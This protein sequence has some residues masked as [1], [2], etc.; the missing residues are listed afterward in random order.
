MTQ[1]VMHAYDDGEGRHRPIYSVCVAGGRA[2]VRAMADEW[3][4]TAER[5]ER[6]L[7]AGPPASRQAEEAQVDPYLNPN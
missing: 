1:L 3:A 6:L 2:F 7:N 5:L 4:D